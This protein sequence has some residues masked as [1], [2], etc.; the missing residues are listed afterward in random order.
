MKA[1]EF[2]WALAYLLPTPLIIPHRVSRV[3]NGGRKQNAVGGVFSVCPLPTL[4]GFL[5]IIQGSSGLPVS[6]LVTCGC[7]V[8]VVHTSP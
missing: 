7:Y 3:H 6:P 4:C 5:I 8:P 1:L 2:R